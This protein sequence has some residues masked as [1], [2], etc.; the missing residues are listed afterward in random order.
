MLIALMATFAVGGAM[1]ANE[2]V[3]ACQER[4]S[5][6]FER[7]NGAFTVHALDRQTLLMEGGI[8]D[9]SVQ[10]FRAALT[11]E[12]RRIVLNSTGG[13]VAP[14]IDIAEDILAR[15]L[16]VEV[17]GICASSC[18]NYLFV[19]GQTKW[20]AP[21]A[22]VLWHGAPGGRVSA[23]EQ[24]ER[25]RAA[26]TRSRPEASQVEVEATIDRSISR[27]LSEIER[28]ETLYRHLGISTRILYEVNDS[29]GVNRVNVVTG[30]V[31]RTHARW[32]PAEVLTRCLGIQNIQAG[33]EPSTPQEWATTLAELGVPE[34]LT[35]GA[36]MID[37]QFCTPSQTPPDLTETGEF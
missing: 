9:A 19:A 17:R 15:G 27:W 10:A 5:S 31:D 34:R 23:D 13:S 32:V 18:A 16:D 7:S 33:Q 28:Q 11:D 20:I 8:D 25:F 21:G 24:R 6:P 14:A 22:L 36:V 35:V 12:T 1:M 30:A 3:G 37:D 4:E 29:Q 2:H 26:I